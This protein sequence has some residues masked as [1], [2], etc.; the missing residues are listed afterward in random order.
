MKESFCALWRRLS[1]KKRNQV[2]V[3]VTNQAR[4]D[5]GNMGNFIA[6]NEVTLFLGVRTGEWGVG[7]VN[8]RI[9]SVG[10]GDRIYPPLFCESGWII[11]CNL[12]FLVHGASEIM[13]LMFWN[14]LQA[15]GRM[16]IYRGFGEEKRWRGSSP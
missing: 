3:M 8:P 15:T 14:V 9:I 11:R 1:E 6:R 7:R 12:R 16:Q 13:K 5:Y 10:S 4:R 2:N